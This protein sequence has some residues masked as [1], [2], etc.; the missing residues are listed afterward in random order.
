MKRALQVIL[1]ISVCGALFSGALT[2][3]EWFGRAVASCPAPGPAGTVFGYPACVY[4]FFMYVAIAG[5]ATGGLIAGSS[6][7]GRR[8]PRDDRSGLR[9]PLSSS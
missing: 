1:G 3:L 2:Y 9:G 6:R 7:K 8:A 4:G 5:T